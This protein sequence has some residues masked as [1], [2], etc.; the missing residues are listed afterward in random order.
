VRAAEETEVLERRR[1][2]GPATVLLYAVLVFAAAW[3]LLPF[4]WM[5]RSSLCDDR[6]V[7]RALERLGDF[8]PSTVH[9]GNYAEVFRSVPLWRYLLN[10]VAISVGVVFG[11]ILSSS[12]CAYAFTFCRVPYRRHLFYGVLATMM[13]PG[14]VVLVPSFILFRELGWIDTLKPLIVPA[15]C[16]SAFAIFLFRQFFLGLPAELIEAARMDGATNLE[17]Y[18]RVV[19]PLSRPV[20]VTVA[21]FAF[22]GTW[23][24]FMGPLIFLN[25]QENWTLQLG[26]SSFVG[27]VA[28]QFN[29]LMAC[30]VMVLLP[31]LAVFFCLQ[32][33]FI[34]G[35]AMTGL[36]G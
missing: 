2:S 27:Q 16:G 30:A 23:N 9:P 28:Q 20:T 25:S 3:M 36:K 17:I 12:L 10:S 7:V 8:V 13:L 11:T 5:V 34:R 29:L 22:M 19:M 35:I 21:I 14:V 4:A 31:V 15:F 32:R 1:R 26:L 24:D 18:W 33:Y 6:E